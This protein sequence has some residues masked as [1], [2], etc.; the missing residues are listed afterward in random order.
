MIFSKLLDRASMRSAASS[1]EVVTVESVVIPDEKVVVVIPAYNEEGSI[2]SVLTGLMNQTRMPDEIHVIANGC[3]DDTVF[4]ASKFVGTHRNRKK[5]G[6]VETV[7]KVHDAGKLRGGKVDALNIGYAIAKKA[8]ADYFLGVD[9][10]THADRK[11]IEQLLNEMVSD[12]RIG[13]IS[14]IYGFD[15]VKGRGPVANF[16]LSGQKAQFG[17][18]HLDHLLRGRKM[19]VLGGQLTL[20]SMEALEEVRV[21]FKQIGP[22]VNDSAVED[23]L[24]SLYLKSCGYRTLI[25]SQARADVGPMLSLGSLAAQG[26]KWGTGG[27]KLL[28]QFPVHPS[29]RQ[30]WTETIGMLMNIVVRVLFII[31][32]VASLSLGA[33]VF[34]PIWLIPPVLA[35]VVNIRMTFTMENRTWKDWLYSVTFIGPEIY[36]WLRSVFFIRYWWEVLSGGEK[37]N[38][39]RQALAESGRG[40]IGWLA[41]P[42]AVGS[43]VVGLGV[44]GWTLLDT[45]SQADLVSHGWPILMILTAILCLG[46][47]RKAI[48]PH[49]G[50][51]V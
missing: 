32:L 27:A 31:L 10:D 14:A 17:G 6:L 51:T 5:Q 25:S 46:L 2:G 35:W 50:F 38:W 30:K 21:K 1:T 4:E 41:W 12:S 47:L 34:N 9:G 8:G 22:W 26:H 18:F 16:L 29:I 20:F 37:D 39:A 3:T 11:A 23:A 44:W 19:S 24:L 13:G 28:L 33:F 40:G 49:R 36:M 45:A 48:R 42:L 7:V 43:A 15:D